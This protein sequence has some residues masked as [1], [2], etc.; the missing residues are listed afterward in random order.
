M[1]A[2]IPHPLAP[3]ACVTSSAT[4]IAPTSA[5]RHPPIVSANQLCFQ[6]EL[7][8]YHRLVFENRE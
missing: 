1:T 7:A 5:L 3:R 8:D 6:L 2:P 4:T